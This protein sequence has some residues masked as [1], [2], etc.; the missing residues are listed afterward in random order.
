ME[1]GVVIALEDMDRASEGEEDRARAELMRKID[2]LRARLERAPLVVEASHR[3]RAE[4]CRGRSEREREP[5]AA[6]S[7]AIEA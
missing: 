4:H 6:S 3:G 7:A 5:D 2:A 1:R